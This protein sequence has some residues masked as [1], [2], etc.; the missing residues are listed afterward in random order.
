MKGRRTA[1]P[2]RWIEI[3]VPVIA[4]VAFGGAW[5]A[6]HAATGRGSVHSIFQALAL[7][8]SAIALSLRKT[9]PTISLA[10]IVV[11]YALVDLDTILI[12]PILLAVATVA[13]LRGRRTAGT[14]AAAT[15]AVI[16]GMPYIHGDQVNVPGYLI[17]HV[18]AVAAAAAIGLFLRSRRPAIAPPADSR[19]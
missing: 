15:A 18:L 4:I 3:V 8:E 17:P 9:K 13:E 19:A 12:L 5:I 14:A 2:W 6:V 10:G 16:A 1:F 7:A 11:V